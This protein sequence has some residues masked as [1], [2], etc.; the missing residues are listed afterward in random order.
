[1]K[2]RRDR[3]KI[4]LT[5]G[6]HS[7]LGTKLSSFPVV[8]KSTEGDIKSTLLYSRATLKLPDN[9]DISGPTKWNT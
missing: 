9:H 5:P 6:K 4:Y 8:N 2:I 7:I 3:G 1:M